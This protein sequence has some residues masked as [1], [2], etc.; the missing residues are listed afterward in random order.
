VPEYWGTEEEFYLHWLT[1]VGAAMDYTN[2]ERRIV[3]DYD[4]V[5]QDAKRE[6]YR[7]AEF[8]GIDAQSMEVDAL[9]HYANGFL[10]K[11]LRHRVDEVEDLMNV[12]GYGSEVYEV[13]KLLRLVAIGLEDIESD[14]VA[15][16]FGR[17]ISILKGCAKELKELDD[18]ERYLKVG[19]QEFGRSISRRVGRLLNL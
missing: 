15:R 17:R 5:M 11:K 13:F 14:S 4:L 12:D 18:F 7:L 1:F 8:I 3:V 19:R 9:D 10:S 2:N 6:L 16:F